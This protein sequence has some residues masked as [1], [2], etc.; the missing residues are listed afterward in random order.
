MLSLGKVLTDR[1]TEQIYRVGTFEGKI[2]IRFL[3]GV[4]PTVAVV[5][6]KTPFLQTTMATATRATPNKW[7]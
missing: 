3:Q 7:V 4:V 6:A 1:R 2:Y 5:I